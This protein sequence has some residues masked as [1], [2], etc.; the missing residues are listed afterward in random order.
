MGHNPQQ[1]RSTPTI[2]PREV[3][4]HPL[5]SFELPFDVTSCH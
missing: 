3:N 1:S 2:P 4:I 5:G